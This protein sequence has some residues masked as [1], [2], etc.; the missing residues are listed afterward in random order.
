MMSARRKEVESPGFFSVV[1]GGLLAAS[2]GAI[3][4]MTVLALQP[5]VLLKDAEAEVPPGHVGY[6]PGDDAG[7][8][9]WQSLLQQLN[10]GGFSSLRLTEGN[11]NT[12]SRNVFKFD[13]KLIKESSSLPLGLALIPSAPN[14]RLVQADEFQISGTFELTGPNKKFICQARGRFEPGVTGPTFVAERVYIGTC[15]IPPIAGLPDLFFR[16]FSQPFTQN[17]TFGRMNTVW[18]GLRNAEVTEE[19]LVL[20]TSGA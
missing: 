3:A 19:A 4:A 2:F 8:G 12:L 13:S 16:A 14:F 20:D 18:R 17:E 7:G 10:E 11:L 9:D 1:F 5:V 6:T 15:P